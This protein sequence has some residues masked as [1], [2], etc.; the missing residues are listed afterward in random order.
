ME[1]TGLYKEKLQVESGRILDWKGRV[2]PA[3][4]QRGL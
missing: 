3:I 1:D 2:E 4:A